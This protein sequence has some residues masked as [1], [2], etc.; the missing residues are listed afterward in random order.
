MKSTV[1]GAVTALSLLLLASFV[2]ASYISLRTSV[3]ATNTTSIINVTHLGD[4]TA[5]QVQVVTKLLGKTFESPIKERFEVGDSIVARIPFNFSNQRTGL[6]PLLGAVHYQDANGY[7]FSVLF[8]KL[9]ANKEPTRS[10]IN[11]KL[12]DHEIRDAVR[13]PVTLR[14]LGE[15]SKNVHLFLFTSDEFIVTDN[16]LS[17]SIGPK[18]EKS[19]VFEV[20]NFGARA[21]S[22]YV[23]YAVAEYDAQ[24]KHYSSVDAGGMKVL[25][26][27]N[28]FFDTRTL[29]IALAVVALFLIVLQFTRKKK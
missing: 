14:N 6:Y 3:D 25:L 27:K 7:L 20:K 16:N 9:V 4:E 2:S 8:S 19:E 18:D 28:R 17:I 23:F 21:G 12:D 10:E 13:V 1:W 22:N 24:D 5:Y 29:I 15:D 26:E 11:V